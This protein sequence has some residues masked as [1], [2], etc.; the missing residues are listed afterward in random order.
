MFKKLEDRL[1]M[2]NKTNEILKR[3]NQTFRDE[4]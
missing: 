3:P 4:D 2:L 1:N